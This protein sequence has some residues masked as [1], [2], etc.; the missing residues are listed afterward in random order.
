[1]LGAVL[2]MIIGSAA[3]LLVEMLDNSFKKVE[4]VEQFLGVP[5]LAT[6]PSIGTIKNKIK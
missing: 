4:E 2:G 3:A 1:M 6:I 5:V